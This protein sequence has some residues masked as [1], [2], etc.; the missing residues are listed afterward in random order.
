[1]SS[2]IEKKTNNQMDLARKRKIVL[3]STIILTIVYW[4]IALWYTNK[5]KDSKE[6]VVFYAIFGP[7]FNY[8]PSL[9]FWQYIYQFGITIVMFLI[10]PF[11]IAKF[12]LNEDFKE[13]GL[14]LGAKKTGLI[15]VA[16]FGP[17]AVIVAP[18]VVQNA[19]FAAEYPLTKLVANSWAIL[20]GYEIAY[21]FYYFSYEVF[22]RGYLQFGLKSEEPRRNEII[23]IITIQ[24]IIT[25]L[26]HIGKPIEEIITAG[27][28]GPILGYFAFKLNSVHYGMII[29]FIIGGICNDIF[30]LIFLGLL[31]TLII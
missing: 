25:I 26:F 7:I 27:I 9:D 2:E 18:L 5:T 1:M 3:L 19:T 20:I 4:F 8:D 10:V 23:Y 28:F 15:L 17:L 24:T 14:K 6:L 21:F 29:H 11:L 30:N 16:I 13:Y 31:P 22:Y 12:L